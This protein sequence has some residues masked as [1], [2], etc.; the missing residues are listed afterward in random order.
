MLLSTG[1]GLVLQG[2]DQEV[3]MATMK[4]PWRPGAHQNSGYLFHVCIVCNH[5]LLGGGKTSVN[6]V[7]LHMYIVLHLL[8]C[9]CLWNRYGVSGVAGVTT[10]T[11]ARYRFALTSVG[12][13]W[14]PQRASGCTSDQHQCWPMWQCSS[15]S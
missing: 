15:H 13:H 6:L 7:S 1:N 12:W 11:P 4:L 14:T 10:H 3:A 8:L 9:V 5:L 2:C